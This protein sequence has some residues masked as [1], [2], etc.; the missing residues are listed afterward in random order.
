MLGI[1]VLVL[2]LGV[3]GGTPAARASAVS[4]V[5]AGGA[6]GSAATSS[7]TSGGAPD[8]VSQVRADFTPQNRT[9]SRTRVA[10][11]FLSPFYDIL[12]GLLLLATG[13]S[14]RM[15]DVACARFRGLYGRTLAYLAQFLLASFVLELPLSFYGGFALEH[16][17]GLSTQSFGAWL[18]DQGK[19]VAV[20][21]FFFG[22]TGL[23][24]LAYLVIRRSPTRWWLWLALGSIPVIA[25]GTLIEPLVIDPLYNKF[26]P[27]H[28]QELRAKIL[29]LAARA[30]IPGR[31]VYEVDKSRQTKKY[32]AY[33]NGFGPSQRI[34]LWDTTLEGM[35]EDEILAVMAHEMGHYVLRHIWKGIAFY[36][37]LSFALFYCSGLIARWATARFGAR[38]GFREMHD[39]ASLPLLGVTITLLSFLAM[40]LINGFSR[41]VEHE[42]DVFGLEVTHLNDAAAR[43]FIKLGSQ[44]KSDPE[45]SAFVKF[46]EYSHPPMIERIRFAIRYRPWM[47][48]KPNR[49]F[50][51]GS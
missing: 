16:R 18:G 21:L 36:S 25:G 50:K 51:P 44:N 8:Y 14:A 9:Y 10:L 31:N 47:E 42:A 40:P 13:L 49:V 46:F 29:T 1:A 17:Y 5:P 15:R 35:K 20:N 23:L 32:N 12:A 11:A 2:A 26:Q 37:L 34:V 22:V 38:W 28:D 24:A 4:P 19:D 48:G 6:G 41:A 30:G 45:P 39:L 33:V 7:T 27:L 43:A 3:A